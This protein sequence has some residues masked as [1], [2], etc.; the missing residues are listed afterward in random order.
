VTRD[1]Q[2]LLAWFERQEALTA[3]IGFRLPE[4]GED[5]SAALAQYE[6]Q[7]AAMLARPALALATTVVQA[8]PPELENH[9]RTVIESL[10]KTTRSRSQTQIETGLFD[11]NCLLSFQKA[12]VTDDI[13]ARVAGASQDDWQ[14]LADICLPLSSVREDLKGT[15]DKDG[16]GV[17]ISS[18]NPN[19]R[20]GPAQNISTSSAGH[21]DMVGFSITFGSPHVF[22]AEYKGRLFLKDGYHRCYGLLKRGIRLIPALYERAQSFADVHSG[23]NSLISQEYLLGPR[24]PRLVDFLDPTV[25]S[26]VSQQA[27]RKTI[28]IRA[29][30]FV[31]NL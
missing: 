19:L 18:L 24:P 8:L 30:E 23:S 3:S 1:V 9:G 16:R 25:S 14:S 10:R 17:T 27:F 22:V 28:R 21:A 4:A 6:E 15:F 5:V 13:D 2:L 26:K 20:V 31:V 29:E 7:H 11:L 12:I